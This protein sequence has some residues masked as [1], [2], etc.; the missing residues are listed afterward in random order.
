M[1]TLDFIKTPKKMGFETKNM[2][3]ERVSTMKF[4]T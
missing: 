4:D 2:A 1:F 3:L